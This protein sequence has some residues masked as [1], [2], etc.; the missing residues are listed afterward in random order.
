[1]VPTTLPR[2]ESYV[3]VAECGGRQEDVDSAKRTGDCGPA[4]KVIWP[5]PSF[6]YKLV[7]MIIS[8][9]RPLRSWP[10]HNMGSPPVITFFFR[11]LL[12]SGPCSS[13]Y[14]T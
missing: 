13:W 1:M 3:T 4:A 7:I 9:E 12:P 11:R 5:M 6:T 2:S 8:S 10:K 14:S